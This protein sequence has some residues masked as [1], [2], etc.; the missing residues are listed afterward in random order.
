MAPTRASER[1]SSEVKM[2]IVSNSQVVWPFDGTATAENILQFVEFWRQPPLAEV[3]SLSQPTCECDT[4]LIFTSDDIRSLAL[5]GAI[6]RTSLK[7]PVRQ[8]A[9]EK[10]GDQYTCAGM[11]F[12]SK[13]HLPNFGVCRAG[14]AIQ[15]MPSK[16]VIPKTV[17]LSPDIRNV[18]LTLAAQIADMIPGVGTSSVGTE[19]SGAEAPAEAPEGKGAPPP[20]S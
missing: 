19:A 18:A 15:E 17:K 13:L 1:M 11:A 5:V 9:C 14:T 16:L 2:S 8:I 4:M 10:E 3:A 6:R 20:P 12:G 7:M